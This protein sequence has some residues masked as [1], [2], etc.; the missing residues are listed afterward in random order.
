MRSTSRASTTV[1]W[2]VTAAGER[3]MP[4]G[5]DERVAN[6]S[7]MVKE[8]LARGFALGD[9]YVDPLVFPISVDSSYGHHCFDAIRALRRALRRRDSHYR[10][11]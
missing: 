6:A 11:Q 8:A 1:A 10:R 3:G 4:A 5:A 2:C 7:R 9:L